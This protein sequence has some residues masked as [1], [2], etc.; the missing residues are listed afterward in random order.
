MKATI[1]WNGHLNFT[2][3]ADSGYPVSLDGDQATNGEVRGASPMELL[4]MGLGGCTTMDVTHFEVKVDVERA[5]EH[6]KVFTQAAVT[7]VIYGHDVD[8]SAV[9][10]AMELSATRYC[11]A[12]AMF[13]QVFP[14]DRRYEIYNDDSNGGKYVVRQGIMQDLSLE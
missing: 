7:Y 6:P 10:R 11:P 4:A 8:E 1:N 13:E 12:Q 5:S 2:A 3:S 14:I 9:L